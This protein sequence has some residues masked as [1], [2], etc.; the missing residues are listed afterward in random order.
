MKKLNKFLAT[1][2]LVATIVALPG[3]SSS[4]HDGCEHEVKGLDHRPQST[5]TILIPMRVGNITI[6]Q[7]FVQTRP[8]RW[9]VE[10]K[11]DD[12]R[13]ETIFVSQE[14]FE[15]LEIGGTLVCDPQTMTNVEPETRERVRD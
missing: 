1:A 4:Q 2:A 9:A 3:C 13:R 14:V 8:E 10:I 12:G 7:P 11:H 6:M 5:S 15:S